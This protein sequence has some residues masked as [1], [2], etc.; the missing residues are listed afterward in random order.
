MLLMALN[1]EIR[2]ESLEPEEGVKFAG[3]AEK[4]VTEMVDHMVHTL[5]D[6]DVEDEHKKEFCANETEKTT[7]LKQE[8]IDLSASLSANIEEFK[9]GIANLVAEIKDLNGEVYTNDKEVFDATELRQKEHQEFIDTLSTMD[10]AKR[11]IDKAANR[12]RDFYHPK[13]MKKKRDDVTSTA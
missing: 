12:L 8:K 1:N 5:H 11:L 3:A 10:T 2:T 9:D 4:V 6:E 13:M 7:E